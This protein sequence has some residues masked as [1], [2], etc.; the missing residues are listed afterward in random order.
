MPSVWCALAVVVVLAAPLAAQ[1]PTRID[2]PHLRIDTYATGQV[3]S[4]GSVFS[5]VFEITPRQG[6]HVY[7][8]GE[9]TYKIV[10]VMLEP[11][12]RLVV[13]PLEYPASEIY[14]FV[15][16]KERVPV[17]QKPF[18]LAQRV[19]VSTAPEYRAVLA[20]TNRMTIRGTLDYQACD[21]RICYPPRSIPVSYSVRLRR[22]GH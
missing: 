20:Q 19:E 6:I 4:P 11:N 10:R 1:Q 12:P 7:A 21:D 14:E 5:L 2:T 8:P 15:P 22:S 18:R 17:F 9:H 3:V 16:L 13:H